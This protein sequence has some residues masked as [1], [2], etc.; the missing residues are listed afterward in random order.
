MSGKYLSSVSIRH[1]SDTD[2]T[3]T[4]KC[5]CIIAAW[6]SS[7]R[8][9]NWCISSWWRLG[10]DPHHRESYWFEHTL[11]THWLNPWHH[12]VYKSTVHLT[13]AFIFH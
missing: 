2:T 11:L 1:V 3:L 4:L 10:A 13:M 8:S 9:T 6:G 5:P 7:Y 12:R